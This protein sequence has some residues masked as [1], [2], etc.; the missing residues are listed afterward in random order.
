[1]SARKTTFARRA[2]LSGIAGAAVGVPLLEWF[3]AG[4]AAAQVAPKRLVILTT[5]NGTNPAAHWPTG[6]G[7]DFSL[8]TILAPFAEYRDQ[9][10][11]LRGVDNLAASAT[12]VNGHT[13]AVRCML[14][15]RAASNTSNDDYTAAGGIS[16]DQHIAN[17]V[18]AGTR[19]K[20]LELVTDYIYAH[21]QNYC[22]FYG[23]SQPAPFEDEPARLFDR[24]F[25][26]LGG[27][28][29][30][31][32]AAARRVD[33]RS[34]LDGVYSSYAALDGRVS[35][36]DR[37]RLA[38][39]LDQVRDLEVRI[40]AE[41]AACAIPDRPA[42]DAGGADLGMDLLV[43]ALA[44]DLTR[45][46]T[47]RNFFWDDW[48]DLG[49]TGSYHDDWLHNVTSTPEAADM[50]NAVKRKQA[51]RVVQFL[52]K[53]RAVPEG[54]GTLLDGTLVVWIDEF[55]HGYAHRH[56]EVPYVMV[57]GSDR[58]MT[59][60]RYH[61]FTT[62]VSTNRVLNSLVHLMDAG[63]AGEIGDPAFDNR[64][65]AELA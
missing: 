29:D 17:V 21:P 50:V 4:R 39:H 18:G 3:S 9:M 53:L 58:F 11:V 55:C 45:V 32:V 46:A 49:A 20:S 10:V 30:D 47:I 13:D 8:S 41:A 25:G 31:P 60:G 14:T 33:R 57:T 19:F 7:A 34:V 44:C 26:D 65:L 36:A 12:N 24:V 40:T 42:D 22:S 64:P 48:A 61:H 28:V 16:V 15:G 23:A 54:D 2:L 5:P 52:D 1:M 43:R 59:P 37:Q 56:D 35:A 62:P 6:A 27:P 63:D 38:A 51:E